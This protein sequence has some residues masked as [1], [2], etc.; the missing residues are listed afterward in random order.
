MTMELAWP[1]VVTLA[2]S[3]WR[4][5]SGLLWPVCADCV[6]V[7]CQWHGCAVRK[8]MQ[9]A[10]RIL[11][12]GQW[13]SYSTHTHTHIYMCVCACVPVCACMCPCVPV[14]ACI[15]VC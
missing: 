9:N 11:M 14:C 15:H 3:D 6:I 1:V 13:Q 10:P 2:H 8:G 7:L 4:C 5:C 12:F